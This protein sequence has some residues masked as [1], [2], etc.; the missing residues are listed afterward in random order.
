MRVDRS[1]EGWRENVPRE[2]ECHR[3]ARGETHWICKCR[4]RSGWLSHC[5]RSSLLDSLE[6]QYHTP[7]AIILQ[8]CRDFY[9]QFKTVSMQHN[10]SNVTCERIWINSVKIRLLGLTAWLK[11]TFVRATRTQTAIYYWNKVISMCFFNGR[12]ILHL[13]KWGFK[14][15][16]LE[17]LIFING[18]PLLD[19]GVVDTRWAFSSLF[20]RN[21]YLM[22]SFTV[23]TKECWGGGS[24]YLNVTPSYEMC[25]RWNLTQNYSPFSCEM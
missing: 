22:S 12:N 14:R 25:L 10:N 3:E 15:H 24:G 11:D 8:W 19:K 1:W 13:G 20:K 17:N 21:V 9:L 2:G 5:T 7:Q 23:L 16:L 6:H 18:F 4:Q